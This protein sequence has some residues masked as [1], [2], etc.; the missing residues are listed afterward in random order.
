MKYPSFAIQNLNSI[1]SY[2]DNEEPNWKNLAY[3]AKVITIASIGENNWPGSLPKY[4][5]NHYLYIKDMEVASFKLAG[6][7]RQGSTIS[8][9]Q[10][11]FRDRVAEMP[12]LLIKQSWDN[13]Q[14]FL[15]FS[16]LYTGFLK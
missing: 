16:R 14:F 1:Y 10:I 4:F 11:K 7:R 9:N 15:A 5:K 2:P 12:K 3:K 6:L 13:I 8:G